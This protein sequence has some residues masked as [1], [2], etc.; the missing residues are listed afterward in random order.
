MK[1]ILLIILLLPISAFA[2]Q[3][4]KIS[5]ENIFKIP[6]TFTFDPAKNNEYIF[7]KRNAHLFFKNIDP[8]ESTWYF[9]DHLNNILLNT[10]F[11]AETKFIPLNN[12]KAKYGFAWYVT[13]Q[14]T[15]YF[16]YIYPDENA[17]L[18]NVEKD[19]D[20]IWTSGK[21][22][23]NNL[24]DDYN[25][26]KIKRIKGIFLVF[27]NGALQETVPA[28]LLYTNSFGYIVGYDANIKVEYL[29]LEGYHRK[30]MIA[31]TKFSNKQ[32]EN[33]GAAINTYADELHP[34]ISADGKVLY[35]VRD[36]YKLNTGTREKQD[37]WY[38]YSTGDNQWTPARNIGPP[39]N[40]DQSE[41][42]FFVSPDNN[43]IYLTHQYDAFGDYLDEGIAVSHRTDKGWSIPENIQIDNYYNHNKYYNYCMSVDQQV[44]I[45]ALERNDSRG[46]LDLYV[47]FR[48]P[49]GSY[50]EPINMGDDINTSQGDFSP[51]LAPDGITLYFASEGH[52]GYGSADIFVTKRLDNTW[53]HWSTPKNLGPNIN[54]SDWDAYFTIDAKG[55]YAYLVSY[56]SQYGGADIYRMKIKEEDRPEPVVI[57]Y[58]TVYDKETKKPISTNISYTD[59]N[60][61]K[62]VAT[63]LSSPKTGNYKIVLP[64]GSKYNIYAKLAGYYPMTDFIDLKSIKV[65]QYQEIRKDLYLVPIKKNQT[66][67]LKTIFFKQASAKLLPESYEELN[68]LAKFLKEN[69]EVK[70]EI[71]GHTNNLGDRVKLMQLSKDRAEAVKQYLVNKGINEN[72]ITTKG[73]GPDRPIASNDTPEG[74]KKNQRVEFKII[75]IQQ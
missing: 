43:T 38:S 70:I 42:V 75:E 26:V 71:S 58:G 36:N 66:V 5:I 24:R 17:I 39:I 28:K 69:P 31:Q 61:N 67:I 30:I 34:T 12:S 8:D 56:N 23:V 52:P 3:L 7:S 46:D 29:K 74:R 27:I 53:R 32:K 47:S 14:S 64:Y 54:T 35:F 6:S 9:W 73:Y 10:D 4:E 13:N 68:R 44:L 1:K 41:G 16:L 11:T 63:T 33:L 72:R 55:E 25:I 15:G 57:V 2:Q 62:T 59:L 40:T 49:D 51:F 65:K 48:K 19:D 20:T 50:T 21:I 60:T 22:I 18:I 37:I 45:M